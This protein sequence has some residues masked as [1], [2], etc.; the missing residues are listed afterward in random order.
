MVEKAFAVG[1]GRHRRPEHPGR[2]PRPPG[3]GVRRRGRPRR[4][5]GHPRVAARGSST[6]SSPAGS[7]RTGCT[8][9]TSTSRWSSASS[10]GP[11]AASGR[12]RTRRTC[13]ATS[14]PSRPAPTSRRRRGVPGDQALPDRHLRRRQP[15]AR[16]RAALGAGADGP[17]QLAHLGPPRLP[18]LRRGARAPATCSTRRCAPPTGRWSRSNA[19]GCL[20]VFST[21]YPESSWQLPWLHSLF[22]NAPA[23]AAGVAAALRAKGREDIRV[24]GQAGDGGTVDIGFGMPVGHVRA[25]RRRALRLLRQRGL[26]EHRR[27]ALRRDPAGRADREHQ[28]ARRRARQRLRPGQ[29]RAR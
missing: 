23:V 9:S 27:A 21:P 3:R 8:S 25:Q 12:A 16:P 6:T 15:A 10:S 2:D 24:V 4:P 17:L 20:E 28:G 13:C 18:G 11:A 1:C 19:T 26:H 14:A 5:A 7:T 22:G 29:E